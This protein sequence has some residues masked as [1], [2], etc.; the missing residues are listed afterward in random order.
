MLWGVYAVLVSIMCAQVSADGAPLSDP[1]KMPNIGYLFAGYDIMFGNPKPTQ[2]VPMDPGYRGQLFEANY[3]SAVTADGRYALPYGASIMSAV[4]CTMSFSSEAISGAKSYQS[5]LS[6]KASVSGGG[7]GAKFSASTDYQKVSEGASS[8]QSLYTQAEAICS[9]YKASFITLGG[10][11]PKL[12]DSFLAVLAAMPLEYSEQ[13]YMEF[14]RAYGT[15]FVSSTIMGSM[16]GEQSKFTAS[17]WRKMESSGLN[18]KV[19]ASYSGFV[20]AAASVATDQQKEKAEQFKTNSTEQVLY[21]LGSKPPTDGE[22]QTWMSQ[23]VKDP[24]PISVQLVQMDILLD[25]ARYG[26]IIAEKLGSDDKKKVLQANLKKAFDSYCN[27]LI[28][29]G[30]IPADESCEGPGPDPAPP[31]G[32]GLKVVPVNDYVE[33]YSD[34]GTGADTDLSM[35]KPNLKDGQFYGGDACTP[36]HGEPNFGSIALEMGSDPSALADPIGMVWNWDSYH[37]GGDKEGGFFTPE[38]PSGYLPL[39]SV[40]EQMFSNT[41]LHP[42]P[43]Y[44]PKLKCVKSN[45]L[46]QFFPRSVVWTDRGSGGDHDGSMWAGHVDTYNGEQLAGPCIG[47]KGYDFF[48]DWYYLKPELFEQVG[49]NPSAASAAIIV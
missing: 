6:V 8:E 39:G 15:H 17:A 1:V 27:Y 41:N 4:G 24:I 13:E 16:Y 21:S 22:V 35:W 47:I 40:G 5:S 3:G 34:K 19:A 30:T 23:V 33:S 32:P 25:D 14:I 31:K 42:S 20:S 46:V 45:Y 26:K 37:T 29:Q 11:G 48:T 7:W 36:N 38:C 43:L 49:S 12:Q 2:G 10:Q 18:I 44:W 9:S 28:Q